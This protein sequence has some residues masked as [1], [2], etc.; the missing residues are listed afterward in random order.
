MLTG[1][2]RNKVDAVKARQRSHLAKLDVRS[3]FLQHRAFRG[4]L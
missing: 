1:D 4:E 2:I 3:A